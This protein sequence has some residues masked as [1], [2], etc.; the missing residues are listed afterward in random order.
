MA[1]VTRNSVGYSKVFAIGVDGGTLE[2]VQ[3]WAQAGKLPTFARIM[4][5]GA[6]GELE[7]TIPPITGPAWASF[8]TGKNPGG[9]GVGDWMRRVDGG[10]R[11][12]P[13]NATEIKSRLFWDLLGQAGKRVGI[14]NVPVTYPPRPLNG[15][16]ISG[17]LTP[18]GS[19]DFTYPPALAQQLQQELG[20]YQAH[21]SQFYAK[22]RVEPFL[23]DLWGL[24][25]GRTKAALYLMDRFEWDFFMVHY[26]ATDAVQHALWH[27]MDPKH[28]QHDPREAER[29]GN[30]ILECYQRVDTAVGQLISELDDDTVLLVMSDHGAGS[31]YKYIYLNNWLLKEGYLKL[32]QDPFTLLKSLAFRLGFTPESLYRGM[33][34]LGL[35]KVAFRAQK[36][37]RYNLLRTFFLSAQ[38]IDWGG[39][40]VYSIGNI[41]QIFINLKGR[42]PMGIVEPGAEYEDL[43]DEIMAKLR[44]VRDPETGEKVM[45]RVYKREEVYSGPYLPQ[46]ADILILPKDLSYQAAGLSEFMSNTIM[47]P[48]FGYTGGH[49]MQGLCMLRGDCI[50]PKSELKGARIIDLAPT[51]LYLM[52]VPIP[53]DMDGMVLKGVLEPEFLAKHPIQMAESEVTIEDDGSGF[54]E[55]EAEMIA[56]R[57]RSLGY[58]A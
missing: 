46:M 6:V 51:I 35:N 47:A 36:K 16:L 29:Y 37:T 24:I 34:R 20:S 39:T 14:I 18:R 44:Q 49:R 21:L 52:G 54:S 48:S 4:A 53:A 40:K 3:P 7:S 42:E 45:E 8:M 38:D 56:E 26:F 10:Y 28:P 15:F 25:E 33:A 55:E 13:V 50:R 30:A 31:L 32:K 43:R 9:H 19:Q 27:C 58:V 41:G 1:N 2:L 11:L 17:L 57:L 23:Q 5:Q 22:G 12:T